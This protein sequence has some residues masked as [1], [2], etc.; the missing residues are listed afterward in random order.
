MTDKPNNKHL[1]GFASM[2]KDRQL[3]IARMGG[4]AVPDSKR[5]FTT[6]RDLAKAAGR[7]GGSVI[8]ERFKGEGE[9][10]TVG[11]GTR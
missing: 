8:R 11:E 5:S 2:S 10:P 3:E 6:D 9:K 7:K 4:R 1:R